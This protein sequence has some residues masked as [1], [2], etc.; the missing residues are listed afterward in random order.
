[1]EAIE[2]NK[3]EGAN[4]IFVESDEENPKYK[5]NQANDE[6]FKIS[7]HSKKVDDRQYNTIS[8]EGKRFPASTSAIQTES[9]LRTLQL[10][11]EL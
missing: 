5:I 3:I 8:G 4:T 10:K 7:Y 6:F 9:K 1:M 11:N 2:Q